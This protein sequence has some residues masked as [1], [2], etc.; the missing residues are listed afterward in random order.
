MIAHS[1]TLALAILIAP[2]CA[3]PPA[4]W[5]PLEAE[6]P[7]GALAEVCVL[8]PAERELAVLVFAV[9]DNGVLVGATRK[10]SYFCWYAEPGAHRLESR[11]DDPASREPPR[12]ADAVLDAGRRYYLEQDVTMAR[13]VIAG[14]PSHEL[15][16][17][18]ERA[19][20][21]R[22]RGCDRLLPLR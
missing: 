10:A 19:A 5:R 21:A 20:L 17:L 22:L 8:R 12:V 4:D 7:P 18:D 14:A 16:W 6:A 3:W 2:A 1:N 13:F 11:D 9:R 15:A